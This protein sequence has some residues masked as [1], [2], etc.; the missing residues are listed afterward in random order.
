MSSCYGK[1]WPAYLLPLATD[2][3]QNSIL[4]SREKKYIYKIK[5]G[6]RNSNK[7]RG[8]TRITFENIKIQKKE[9][10]L[11]EEKRETSR[12]ACDLVLDDVDLVY[13]SELLKQCKELRFRHMSRYLSD[14]NLNAL[15]FILLLPILLRHCCLRL[16]CLSVDKNGRPSLPLCLSSYLSSSSSPSLSLWVF[17]LRIFVSKVYLFS[18]WRRKKKFGGNWEV[19]IKLNADRVRPYCYD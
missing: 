12:G 1:N 7:S 13:D 11:K 10:K 9:E 17:S 5:L 4:I 18:K 2:I 19:G 15:F 8:I 3:A 16:F 6:F 14:E